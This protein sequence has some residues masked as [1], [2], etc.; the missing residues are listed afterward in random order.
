L[1]VAG[2][3]R[4]GMNVASIKFC[5]LKFLHA[6]GQGALGIECRAD[7]TEVLSL[8]KAIEHVQRAIAL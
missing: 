5:Q 4:L 7:D 8:L 3:Q 1:A 6:V 2:L